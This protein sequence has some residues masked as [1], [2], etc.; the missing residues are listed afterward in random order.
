MMKIENNPEICLRCSETK[1]SYD[2]WMW[3]YVADIKGVPPD[4]PFILEHLMSMQHA[5]SKNL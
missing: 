4:C 2:A 5:E 1:L 3:C